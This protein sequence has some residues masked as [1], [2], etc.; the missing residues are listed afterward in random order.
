MSR[1]SLKSTATNA[2]VGLALAFGVAAAGALFIGVPLAKAGLN[3]LMTDYDGTVRVVE[4]HG[5]KNVKATGY[6]W[7]SC[8]IGEQAD[9]WRTRFTA[10][11]Q[12]GQDVSGVV[13][14]GLFKGGTMRL[15]N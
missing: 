11:N 14:A 8:G 4:G 10:V 2:A 12:N 9:L 13:C 15:D 7:F 5:F 3:P 6:G 1:S